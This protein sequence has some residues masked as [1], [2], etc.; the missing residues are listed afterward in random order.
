MKNV[1]EIQLNVFW[2][3]SPH[4]KNSILNF[5]DKDRFLDFEN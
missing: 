5:K 1:A 4:W 2:N 3:G